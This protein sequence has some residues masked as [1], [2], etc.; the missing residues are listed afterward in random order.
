[1]PTVYERVDDRGQVVERVQ[2]VPD[3][4]E[5]TRLGVAVIEG[6]GGWRIAPE[7]TSTDIPAVEIESTE[8]NAATTVDTA[9]DAKPVKPASSKEK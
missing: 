5:D 6:K 4:Y 9:A 3:D 2:P 8:V 1:M 7:D